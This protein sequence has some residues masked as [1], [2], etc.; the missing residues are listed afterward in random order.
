[1]LLTTTMRVKRVGD[2]VVQGWWSTLGLPNRRDQERTLHALNQINSRLLDLEDE[3]AELK[4][5]KRG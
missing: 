3:L 1:M 5:P 4:Q 2:R